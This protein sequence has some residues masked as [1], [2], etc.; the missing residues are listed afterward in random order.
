MPATAAASAPARDASP[1]LTPAE[2]ERYDA[3]YVTLLGTTSENARRRWDV[4]DRHGR[5]DLVR[6]IEELRIKA[7]HENTLGLKVQQLVQ[8]GQLVAL[9]KKPGAEIHAR[10]ALK[11]GA[12]VEDL[13]GVA[14]TAFITGGVPAYSLGIEIIEGLE[15]SRA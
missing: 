3:N 12:T 11:A 9:G 2:R 6:L 10:A 8:F 1:A 4:A 13:L 14:E 5:S 15:A 7:I